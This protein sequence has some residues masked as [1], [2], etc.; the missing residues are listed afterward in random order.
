MNFGLPDKCITEIHRILKNYP[1]VKKAILYGSR[2]NGNY[3][4]GSDID[5]TLL[6]DTITSTDLMHIAGDLDD[7]SIPYFVD[8]S[9]FNNIDNQLLHEHIKRVGI[10]FY[11]QI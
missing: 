6:G 3:K 4:K 11:N 9:I 5:I 7:S 1:S 10:L 8:I 2:A